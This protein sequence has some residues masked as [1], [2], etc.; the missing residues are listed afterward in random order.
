MN[1]N[2]PHCHQKFEVEPGFFIGAMYISY[3]MSVGLFLITGMVL[4][5][6]FG[7]PELWVYLTVITT[8]VICLLPLLYRYSRVLYLYWFGGVR[9]QHK[10]KTTR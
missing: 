1:E 7:D 9:Y 8:L 5:H 2:C 10:H 6:L 4:Y 3:A